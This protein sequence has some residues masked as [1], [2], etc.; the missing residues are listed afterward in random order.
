MFLG[1]QE[2]MEFAKSISCWNSKKTKDEN[3]ENVTLPRKSRA[4]H[5]ES[6]AVTRICRSR[7]ATG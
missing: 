2:S 1:Q 5:A 7:Q 6:A 4:V 3:V